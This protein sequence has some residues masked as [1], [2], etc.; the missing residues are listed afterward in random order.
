MNR[1]K[2]SLSKC[3]SLGIAGLFTLSGEAYASS[4]SDLLATMQV[5]QAALEKE[6]IASNSCLGERLDGLLKINYNCSSEISALAEAENNDRTA[7]YTLMSASLKTDTKN[8]GIQWAK[9]RH[10]KYIEGVVREVRLED[11][12]T[13]FWN[14]IGEH[15][16]ES[17]IDRV[18]TKQYAKLYASP[19]KAADIVRDNLP[20]YEAFGVVKQ[21]S[22]DGTRWYQVTEEYVPK[23]KPSNWDPKTI[24][25]ISE[26]DAISWKRALVMRFT[27]SLNR[28]PS[29][30]FETAEDAVALMKSKKA[31][32]NKQLDKLYAEFESG[33]VNRSSGALAIEPTVGQSQD[34]IVMYP[35]LD[36]YKSNSGELYMDGQFARLLE[37]AAQTRNGV[38][39]DS[40]GNVPIDI[41]F[42]MDLTSSM[43][44]YLDQLLSVVKQ[45]V[46]DTNGQDIRFGF[47][48]YQDKDK[49]RKFAFSQKDFT[50]D[51]VVNP[52]DFVK[53]LSKVEAQKIP[54][55]SDDIPEAVLDG[56]NLALDSNQWRDQ[57]AKTIILIGD[58]P[59]RED[60]ISIK[61][62][63]DK[64]YTRKIPIYSLY[65]DA[66]KG[67]VKYSKIGKKQY[68]QLSSTYEGAY[69][70]SREIPHLSVID[71]GS[72]KAFANTVASG[73]NDAKEIFDMFGTQKTGEMKTQEG[74][75]AEL[76]FQQADLL[77]ADPTMPDNAVVGWVADKVM[78]S[79]GREA[80]APMIL[81]NEVELDEL[82]QRVKELKDIGE[83]AMRGDSG[84]TLDFFDL[85]SDNTR[86]TMVDPSAV[87]FRDAFSAPL[88]INNLP[89]DSD[90]M[91]TTRE[92]FHSMDRVQAFV[93]SMN[94]KLRH[95]EDLKRQQGNPNV[96]KKLSMGTSE[97]DRVVGVELNQLP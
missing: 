30:I 87:N 20:L 86:F 78:N 7:L 9:Q 71:G 36:F 4:Y 75:V 1:N 24:G 16:D 65:I 17:N 39:K 42:V 2:I 58:A 3:I 97:R 74:S 51:G 31:D 53:I 80:L 49:E 62:L 55:K 47:V 67:A 64:S 94:N 81:L 52:T 95:Y 43:K 73:L 18:L 76:L 88:G 70:T 33:N 35:L 34:Q 32:R 69:G 96:W 19:T 82:E 25:W 6:Q 44:P 83:M 40:V 63:R 41:V 56:V 59:G 54:V 92:E 29:V 91:S 38:N 57:S 12:T 28:E 89:Y 27:N 22:K 61:E 68:K 14:G 46:L 85:V 26:E 45:F 10:P 23:Q 15:P 60:N 66:S 77:L 5:R 90:I 11:G 37:V 21:E 79:P 48:G 93:R 72:P 8:V 13:T 50:Y 84:T